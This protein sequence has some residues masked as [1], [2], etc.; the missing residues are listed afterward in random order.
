MPQV[1]IQADLEEGE[2]SVGKTLKLLW[3]TLMAASSDSV[4]TKKGGLPKSVGQAQWGSLSPSQDAWAFQ[5]AVYIPG[6]EDC[7]EEE[8]QLRGSIKLKVPIS[9]F[10]ATDIDLMESGNQFWDP[11]DRTGCT[12]QEHGINS[13]GAAR[14]LLH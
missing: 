8:N 7:G 3:A 14:E 12:W 4:S 1:A 9:A 10:L 6:K 13:Q 11:K 5:E 2:G